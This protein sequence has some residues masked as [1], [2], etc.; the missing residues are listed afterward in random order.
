MK[1]VVLVTLQGA[2]IGNRLQNYAL[3]ETIKKYNCIVFTPYYNLPENNTIKKR[4]INLIKIVLGLFGVKKY[5]FMY[6]RY[7]KKKAFDIFDDTYI[8]N[9][10]KV[11]FKNM[12]NE[13]DV[14][15][16]GSDQVW[17]KWSD[18]KNELDYFYLKFISKE[19][20]ISYGASFGFEKFPQEDIE[21]HREGLKD[22]MY[23]SCREE[24]GNR[25]INEI[26]GRDAVVVLDPTLLLSRQE[27]KKI[28][29]KPRAV[30]DKY[31]LIYFL[32]EKTSEYMSVIKKIAEDN[33]LC[34]IDV[35]NPKEEDFFYTT[36][37]EFLWLVENASYICTDSFH[38]CVFSIIF[39]K[40]FL[41]FR[42]VE[43]GMDN[44]YGRIETLFMWYGIDREYTGDLNKIYEDYLLNDIR[45]EIE[46]SKHFL[47][48]SL[49]NIDNNF[50]I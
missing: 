20:R 39:Q 45:G 12:T 42:R 31:L 30:S 28:E 4:L 32:G 10:F 49:T 35:N 18:D 36:P 17:H 43:E 1:K 15:V 14:A 29:K 33:S 21:K 13:Y 40:K 3:Q 26:V 37:D 11:S 2:N 22:I 48:K 6:K 16:T 27:W 19:R 50:L 47:G 41:V 24:S 38:A 25:L 8:D 7:K 46:M 5:T 44:M 9:R 23:L 34:V